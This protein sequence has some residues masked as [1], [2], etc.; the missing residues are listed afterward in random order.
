MSR[1][2]GRLW[3]SDDDEDGDD[4]GEDDYNDDIYIMMKCL[5]STSHFRAEHR[6][7]EVSRPLG[8]ANY[9]PALA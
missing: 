8:L 2:I 9:R 4:V 5:L 3:P 6:R 1:P 7:R